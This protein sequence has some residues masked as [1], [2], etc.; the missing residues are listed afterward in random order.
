MKNRGR[1]K[2]ST[3]T[4]FVVSVVACILLFSVLFV[5]LIF[6]TNYVIDI[7]ADSAYSPEVF[8]RSTVST[9]IEETDNLKAGSGT[10]NV[11]NEI[12]DSAHVKEI[13]SALSAAF[14]DKAHCLAIAY[15]YFEPIY[16][17]TIATGILANINHEGTPGRVEC[18]YYSKDAN[19]RYYHECLYTASNGSNVFYPEKAHMFFNETNDKNANC[20]IHKFYF[21][22]E[23]QHL[24][25]S[26]DVDLFLQIDASHSQPGIGLIQWSGNRRINLLNKYKSDGVDMSSS[27]SI[28]RCE[29]GFMHSELQSSEASNMSNTL[30]ST[31]ASS[32]AE[33]FCRDVIRP[34]NVEAACVERSA[35]A[36]IIW[37]IL[38]QL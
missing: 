8:E 15:E 29:L 6:R 34:D 37:N 5:F 18:L 3:V 27:D 20:K 4:R 7:E 1:D 35:T 31:S 24:A 13:E 28:L 19:S 2:S 23:G 21:Q 9:V 32:A 38:S 16:G 14:P 25:S 11:G 17:P 36:D 30:S 33:H 26:A 12:I 10:V 22:A